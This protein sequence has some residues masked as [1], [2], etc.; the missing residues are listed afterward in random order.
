MWAIP[1]GAGWLLKKK[2]PIPESCVPETGS[3]PPIGS[4]RDSGH[5]MTTTSSAG[6]IMHEGALTLVGCIWSLINM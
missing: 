4:G 5:D 1:T 3:D 6:G 2:S